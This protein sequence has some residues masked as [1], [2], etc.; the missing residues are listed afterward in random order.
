MAIVDP[1]VTAEL[2]GKFSDLLNRDE[3][4][5]L[6]KIINVD[7][8]TMKGNRSNEQ[9]PLHI[10]SAS[11]YSKSSLSHQTDARNFHAFVVMVADS[12]LY[13]RAM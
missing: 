5:K 9:S 12:P 6:R 4:K 13:Y 2:Q 7:R 11:H 8:K 10:V 1:R 3:G